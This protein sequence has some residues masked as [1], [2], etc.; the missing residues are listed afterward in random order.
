MTIKSAINRSIAIQRAQDRRAALAASV[1]TST[2][3]R[4]FQ[5]QI[6]NG[7]TYDVA[8][9]QHNGRADDLREYAQGIH[10][11]SAPDMRGW[12]IVLADKARALRPS[13][14][15][16]GVYGATRPNGYSRTVAQVQTEYLQ[17]AEARKLQ[18]VSVYRGRYPSVGL[19]GFAVREVDPADTF[20]PSVNECDGLTPS[21]IAR[22]RAHTATSADVRTGAQS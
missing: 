10:R 22:Y 5:L 11:D 8:P 16:S 6:F 18:T 9:H 15:K 2:D 20:G 17:W 7:K 13:Y 21:E 19:A 3:Q 14:R 12:R 1:R 4:I